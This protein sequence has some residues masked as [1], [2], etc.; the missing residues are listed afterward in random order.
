[1]LLSFLDM[2]VWFFI[3]EWASFHP[4]SM[5]AMMTGSQQ[6]ILM[7]PLHHQI[8]RICSLTVLKE[9]VMMMGEHH[10]WRII[11][12]P[13]KK[14]QTRRSD[15]LK[16]GQFGMHGKRGS[17][18]RMKVKSI[19]HLPGQ[20]MQNRTSGQQLKISWRISQRQS[21]LK[22]RKILQRFSEGEELNNLSFLPMVHVWENLGLT[23]QNPFPLLHHSF[24]IR[25]PRSK[26]LEGGIK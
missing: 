7:S 8:G 20:K 4:S 9:S 19:T 26:G 23:N 21:L 17:K 13:G 14:E 3:L 6:S 1:M 22:T 15:K 18:K 12:S 25:E 11:G 2:W 5:F 16:D 24:P 10:L